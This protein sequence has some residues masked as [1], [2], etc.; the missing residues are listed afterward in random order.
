MKN[1][2]L[3][4]IFLWIFLIMWICGLFLFYNIINIYNFA[5][6]LFTALIFYCAIPLLVSYFF[7]G[8]DILE[9]DEDEF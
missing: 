6:Y 9:E 4:Y 3:N 2:Y 8:I 7:L 1:V 5:W